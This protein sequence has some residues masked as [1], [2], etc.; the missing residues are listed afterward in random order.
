NHIELIPLYILSL[1][2]FLDKRSVLSIILSSFTFAILFMVDPYYAFFSG[3][4]SVIIFLFYGDLPIKR[5]LLLLVPYYLLLLIITVLMNFN[6]IYDNFYLVDAKNAAEI[7]RNSIP[8]N[9]LTN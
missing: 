1:L 3:L 7:G 5:R 4:F 9:E 2:Y 6:F 8:R